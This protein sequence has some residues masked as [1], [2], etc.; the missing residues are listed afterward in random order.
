MPDET[1]RPGAIDLALT[2]EQREEFCA[3]LRQT[4]GLTAKRIQELAEELYG[5]E[6]GLNAAYTFKNGTLKQH[7]NAIQRA[8]EMAE[9]FRHLQE[10]I[11]GAELHTIADVGAG[12]VSKELFELLIKFMADKEMS[13]NE[14]LEWLD[15]TSKIFDRNRGK[16]H[17]LR[18]LEAELAAEQAAKAEA[19]K[20]LQKLREPSAANNDAQR[21]AVLDEVD[22]IMGIKK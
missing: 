15:A 11:G 17:N 1:H 12:L 9:S 21:Q 2:L 6:V 4:Q 13:D 20:E 22:R 19:A 16:D 7:I 18:K 8:K 10:Q 14:R 5:V 3:L